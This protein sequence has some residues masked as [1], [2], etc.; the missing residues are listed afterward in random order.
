MTSRFI[1]G[2]ADIVDRFDG[3][4]V[5]QFGVLHDG[6]RPYPGVVDCLDRLHALGKRMVL[7]S[8]SGRRAVA[9]RGR[10]EK[11][12]L[13]AAHFEAVVTSGEVAWRALAD[14]TDAF[15]RDLGRRCFLISA[16]SDASFVE[17]LDLE[18]VDDAATADF[19]L[20]VGID[21]PVV[22]L[23]DYEAMLVDALRRGIPMLCANDDQVRITPGGLESA[24]GALAARYANAGGAVHRYGKPLK[25][26]FDRS[27]A[28]LDGIQRDRVLVAGD[29][30]EH[31]IMGAQGA[32]VE[33]VYVRGGIA[34]D[35]SAPS[36][37]QRIRALGAHPRYVVSQFAW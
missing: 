25:F 7:L 36:I 27:L 29:S 28:A 33:S 14:R 24:P 1:A 32:G 31:D 3:L 5:D 17:G 18:L 22:S 21:T 30:L 16:G 15:H 6:D 19:V 2:F 8:N 34:R 9:N 11:I 37:E 35:E 13:P 12:G 23:A 4:I 10:L 26:I 20:V